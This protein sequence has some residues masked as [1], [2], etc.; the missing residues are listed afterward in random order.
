LG[1]LP[2]A[3]NSALP[4]AKRALRERGDGHGHGKKFSRKTVNN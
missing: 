1:D 2:K 3:A 4:L